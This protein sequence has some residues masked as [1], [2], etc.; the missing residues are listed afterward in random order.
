M[1]YDVDLNILKAITVETMAG[2][3]RMNQEKS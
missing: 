3:S 1:I 2:F